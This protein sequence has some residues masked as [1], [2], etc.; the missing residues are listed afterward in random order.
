MGVAQADDQITPAMLERA[1]VGAQVLLPKSATRSV[2]PVT[3]DA[4]A[5]AARGDERRLLGPVEAPERREG[6][7]DGRLRQRQPNPRPPER[8]EVA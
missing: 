7:G 5:R 2:S 3:E 6:V 4:P 1:S 8:K